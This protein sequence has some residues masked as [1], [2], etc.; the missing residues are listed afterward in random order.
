MT[1]ASDR[2]GEA[3]PGIAGCQLGGGDTAIAGADSLSCHGVLNPHNH[4]S[5]VKSS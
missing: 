5:T 2:T 4:I 3:W 1:A